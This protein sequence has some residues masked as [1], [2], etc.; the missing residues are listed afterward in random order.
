MSYTKR[1]GKTPSDSC[2]SGRE[3]D[4]P[5]HIFR[6][7]RWEEERTNIQTEIGVEIHTRNVTEQEMKDIGMQFKNLSQ[8]YS[9]SKSK[10]NGKDKI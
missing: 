4:D 10:K 9:R 1:I 6:C 5:E 7:S 2:P 8:R 3:I